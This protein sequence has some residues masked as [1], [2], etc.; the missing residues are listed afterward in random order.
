M[1]HPRAK[2]DRYLNRELSWPQLNRRVVEEAVNKANPLLERLKFLAIFESNLDEFYM[3]RV[4]GLI[5]QF[6]SRMIELTPDGLTAN[7]QLQ[8]ISKG[9]EPQRQKAGKLLHETLLPELAE[10]GVRIFAYDELE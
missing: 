1:K 2:Q 10:Q 6:E 5:E 4:S 9:A 8:E 7:E 3:V